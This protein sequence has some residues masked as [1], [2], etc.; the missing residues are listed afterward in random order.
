[1]SFLTFGVYKDKENDYRFYNPLQNN[2]KI[3]LYFR[4]LGVA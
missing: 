2:Q 1:M 4:V 3:P